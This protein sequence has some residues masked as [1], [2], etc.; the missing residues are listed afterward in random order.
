M[1]E[2]YPR[3][4]SYEVHV[5]APKYLNEESEAN[6]RLME[7]TFQESH[8]TASDVSGIYIRFFMGSLKVIISE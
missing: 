4:L 3:D 1:R 5:S 8:L 7:E 2:R 6:W